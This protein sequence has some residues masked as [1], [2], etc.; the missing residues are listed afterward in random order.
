MLNIGLIGNTKN[1]EPHVKRI[2][3]NRKINIIGKSSVGINPQLNSF[4]FSIPEFNRIELIERA[5]IILMDNT[6]LLPFKLL[7]DIVK[8]S[9]HIFTTEYLKLTIEECTQLVK[10]TNESGSV[11]Q[12]SNPF[13]FTPAI[14]W[15]NKNVTTPVYVD[16]SYFRPQIEEDSI[17]QLLMILLGVTGISP[18]KIG[19]IAFQSKETDSNFNNVRLEFNDASVVNLN[20]GRFEPL[21]EFK[22]KAYS[23]GQFVTLNFN[24]KTFQCHNKPI[25]FSPYSTTNEFDT[26]INTIVNK[27]RTVSSIEDYLIVLYAVQKINKKLNQF[28][29]H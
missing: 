29:V 26:F 11:V 9:K 13:Y 15:L 28:T 5:D 3:K 1:L 6:S 23:P 19:A 22:I 16:I 10:L 21:N 17:F 18:K 12:V 4:H 25:D 14:Q 2:Q 8:K 27:T 24:N 7:C 20:Y